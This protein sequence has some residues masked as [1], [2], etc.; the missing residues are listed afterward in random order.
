IGIKENIV[1]YTIEHLLASLYGLGIDNI[2][3]LLD[4]NEPPV[5]DGSAYPFVELLTKAE[6]V[7]QDKPK[8]YLIL[9]KPIKYTA[10]DKNNPVE[11][12]AYPSDELKI[13]YQIVYEHP[14]VGTQQ[15]ELRITPENFIKE[16]SHSR[17]FCFDYEIE[18]LKTKG[19]AKGGGLE[20]TL[21]IGIDKI[22]SKEKLRYPDEFV[23]HKL[24]DLLG[25]LYLLG[26]PL[27]AHIVAKRAGHKHNI[28][29]VNLIKKEMKLDMVNK[30]LNTEEI[31]K[32]IPHRE[33]FLMIDKVVITEPEKSAIGYKHL[34]GNEDF[35]RGHFPGNPI[36][37]GVLIVEALAQTACVL[38]LSRPDLKNMLAYFMS[39]ENTKFRKPVLPGDTLELRI[40][41]LRAR[42]KTGKVRG[43]A[44]VNDKLVCESEFMFILVE[45]NKE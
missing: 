15:I 9:D 40:N 42:E 37:P 35:F 5:F 14:L 13:D 24:L 19:L 8:N 27:K 18:A 28:N 34:T 22:Y 44:Y 45:K 29:F 38:F 7:E 12:C 30:E 31:K 41:V 23:R 3:I 39:I 4:N 10:F 43:E 33:P 11:I 36:M 26:K 6:I 21:I 2:E 17:T 32:I 25:D 16:I 20:N 1:V